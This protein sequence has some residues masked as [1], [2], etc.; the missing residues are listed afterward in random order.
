MYTIILIVLSVLFI[1]LLST[2]L[3]VHPFLS[4]IAAAFFFGLFSGMPLEGLVQT[5]NEGFGKTI[6]NIGII[7]IAGIIIGAFLENTGGANA[8]ANKL[9]KLIGEKRVHTTNAFIGY[10][11]SIPVF[12]DSGFIILSSLNKALTKKAKLSLAGTAIALA[13][14][15]TATH[16][17]VPP[18]PGPIA[19]AGIIGADLGTVISIGLVISLCALFVAIQFSK[20]TGK[21]IYIDPDSMN[22]DDK[23]E[24]DLKDAPSAFKSFLPIVIPIILI[25]LRSIAEYPTTPFG[26]GQLKIILGFFGNPVVALFCGVLLSLLLPKKLDKVM[27]ST[28]GWAGQ[29]LKSAAIIIL[30]TGAGGAFGNVLQ[31]SNITEILS[32]DINASWLGIWLPFL[33]A[34]ALKTAQGSS[35]VAIITTASIITPILPVLGLDGDISRA[36][37]VIAIG[38]GSAVISHANDSFFWVVTQMSNMSI[39]Q[40]YRIQSLGTAILGFSAMI[41]LTILSLFI[42]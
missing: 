2:Y 9:I 18:T 30:I 17:M 13:L 5:I 22:I 40:G 29:A 33:V 19:A 41:F 32:N 39:K 1:I 37:V 28:T 35:T 8:M 31:K 3:K 6:G 23:K 27:L 42:S 7:I 14:G 16:T 26:E 20:Y 34:A 24:I 11:I 36:M 38:A 15:L 12:A 21:K 10:I 25:V 4:L